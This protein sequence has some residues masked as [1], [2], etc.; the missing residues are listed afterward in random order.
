MIARRKLGIRAEQPGSIPARTLQKLLT[1]G[2]F[3]DDEICAEY[4]GGVLAS[5]RSQTGRD[6]RAHFS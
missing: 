3:V 6:D 4:F 2:S 1:D 5:S